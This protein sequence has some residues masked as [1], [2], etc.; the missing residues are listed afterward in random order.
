MW[1]RTAATTRKAA[2]TRLLRGY[3]HGTAVSQ[4]AARMATPSYADDDAYQASATSTVLMAAGVA[5]VAAFVLSLAKG[6]RFDRLEPGASTCS[7]SSS[8]TIVFTSRAG[9][10]DAIRFRID[11]PVHAAAA[12]AA[13]TKL[14]GGRFAATADGVGRYLA[15]DVRLLAQ[16]QL[17]SGSTLL[18]LEALQR[19]ADKSQLAGSLMTG[20]MLPATSLPEDIHAVTFEL[21]P[22]SGLLDLYGDPRTFA[23][24]N[25]SRLRDGNVGRSGGYS[26]QDFYS[27]RPDRV[28][29]ALL[30]LFEHSEDNLTITTSGRAVKPE[31]PAE[32]A[33]MFAALSGRESAEDAEKSL[34]S[35][36]A[37]VEV[38]VSILGGEGAS[39]MS[40]LVRAQCGASSPAVPVAAELL[41]ILQR[42]STSDLVEDGSLVS[43]EAFPTALARNF[44]NL[45][46]DTSGMHQREREGERLIERARR[47][48]WAAGSVSR[49]ELELEI[50][51]YLSRYLLGLAANNAT[52]RITLARPGPSGAS[53]LRQEQFSPVVGLSSGKGLWWR[54]ELS[55]LEVPPVKRI[56]AE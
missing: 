48:L 53:Q 42:H 2:T 31:I 12:D 26:A 19:A 9:A 13:A 54:L 36:G 20:V 16:Q 50:R 33:Q 6:P 14:L 30:A 27:G 44:W 21:R 43:E 22:G 23:L 56:L 49:H 45:S 24:Q 47:E 40:A 1:S 4:A 29:R 41:Q 39:M 35:I 5:G 18:E 34:Q 8:N 37:V 17:A 46:P 51:K 11:D 3:R 32:Q 15:A 10:K 7:A 38:L 25:N 28:R 55:H 52:I